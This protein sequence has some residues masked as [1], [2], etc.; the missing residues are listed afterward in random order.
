MGLLISPIVANL[1]V[2]YFER[3]SLCTA[4]TPRHWFRFVDETFV[5]QQESHKQLFLNHINNIDPAIKF[6]VEGQSGEWC[7]SIP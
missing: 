7:Y 3:E 2:E 5:I 4:S 6:T 1:Y